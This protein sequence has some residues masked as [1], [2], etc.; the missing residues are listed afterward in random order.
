MKHAD[1]ILHKQIAAY[2][3]RLE[4]SEAR[5]RSI[6]EHQHDGVLIVNHAGLIQFANQAA[7]ILF[8]RAATELTGTMFGFPMIAG[9]TTELDLIRQGKINRIVEMRVVE[10]VW[11]EQSVF[12]ASLRDI[13]A[14]KQAEQELAQAKDAA[15]S[16]SRAKSRFLATMSHELRT[17]LNGILG[18]V[19]LL[20]YDAALS[21]QQRERLTVIQRSGDHLL[22]LLNDIL[23]ISKFDTNQLLTINAPFN[24]RAVMQALTTVT[25]QQACEKGLTFHY[26]EAPDLAFEVYGDEKRLRQILINLLGNA[27]KF[28]QHGGVTLRVQRAPAA[29]TDAAAANLIRF[30]IEDT[31]IGIAAAQVA[32]IVTPMHPD[33]AFDLQ[34]AGLGLGLTLCRRLLWLLGSSLHVASQLERGSLFWFDLELPE[35]RAAPL[36]R[37]D[38]AAPL[39]ALDML[40]LPPLDMVLTLYQAAL[41]GDIF[42]IHNHLQ[43]IQE[44]TPECATFVNTIR[45]LAKSLNILEIQRLMHTYLQKA[46]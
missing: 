25:R 18:N 4:A 5:F 13:T 15:E 43:I 40:S 44:T 34:L 26:A 16:A 38:S 10:T 33:N 17:P 19:Q 35:R 7:E 41:I 30:E 28:T 14:R 39:P 22:T 23:D 12:L 21:E 46:R 20:Q 11:T 32:E 42:A 29:A 3:H 31:G 2:R 9:E 45:Q 1:D 24:L 36:A 37:V 8:D 27:I 6:I